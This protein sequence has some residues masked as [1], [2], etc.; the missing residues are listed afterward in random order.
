[1]SDQNGQARHFP[2][3]KVDYLITI[4]DL[5]YSLS[6]PLLVYLMETALLHVS[7][8]YIVGEKQKLSS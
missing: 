4:R 2:E 3:D 6:D 7:D 1:M 5:A 8:G